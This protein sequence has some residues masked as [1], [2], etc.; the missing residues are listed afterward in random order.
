VGKAYLQNTRKHKET[1]SLQDKNN[2]FHK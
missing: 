2:L 1:V